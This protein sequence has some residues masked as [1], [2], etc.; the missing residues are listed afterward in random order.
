V[1]LQIFFST[2]NLTVCGRVGQFTNWPLSCAV[3]F[4]Q[5]IFPNIVLNSIV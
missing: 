1:G 3:G 5:N 2:R 4:L